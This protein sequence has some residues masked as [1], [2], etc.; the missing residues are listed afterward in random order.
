MIKTAFVV[1]CTLLSLSVSAQVFKPL[2]V[3]LS[4]GYAHP[5]GKAGKGGFV[6]SIE[7]KYGLGDHLD[8][9]LRLEQA[10]LAQSVTT[11]GGSTSA[12]LKAL[13]SGLLTASY[14]LGAG[15]VRPFLGVGA[16][17]YGVGA[18]NVTY[19]SGTTTRDHKIDSDTRFGGLVRA[20]VKTG[21]FVLSVEYN[22]LGSSNHQAS[23]GVI[24]RRNSYYGFKAGVD[25]G[26][27]R[28]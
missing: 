26:G 20:G 27:G 1:V 5:S 23:A 18:T 28:R 25:I 11:T 4:A 12:D 21:H 15:S 6:Y 2:K 19:T 7:P 14:L 10:F 22:A 17:I 8:V 24:E 9:G 13:T 16:G 3:H